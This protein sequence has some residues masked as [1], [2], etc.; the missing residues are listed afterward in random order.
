MS[1][2]GN[3][4]VAVGRLLGLQAG[5]VDVREVVEG[6]ECGMTIGGIEE[7][8]VGDTLRFVKEEVRKKVLG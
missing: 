7:L 2:H 4:V 5:K 1:V 3:D 6:Q 8:A